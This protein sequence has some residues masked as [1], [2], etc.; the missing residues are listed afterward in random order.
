MKKNLLFFAALLTLISLQVF[1]QPSSPI[2]VEPPK[3]VDVV[4]TPVTLDWNDVIGADCY[5]VEVTTDTTSPEKFEGTCNAP[6]S[7]YEFP[8]TNTEMNTRYYWRVFAC[9]QQGWSQPSAYFNF[10][11]QAPDAIGSIG[12]LSNGV[13]DLIADEKLT[14]SQGNQLIYRLNRAADRLAQS[15]EFYAI[16]EMFMFKARVYIL[17]YSN[18]I[19]QPTARSLNYSADGVIDLISDIESKPVNQPKL[20][21]FLVPKN[22]EVKQNYPNPFNPTTTIEYSI[23]KDAN[24]SLKIFDVLGKEVATLVNDQKSAG[25]YIINW[26]A[27]NFSSG[28]YFYRVTAGDFTDTKKMFLVK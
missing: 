27:S 19:D 26:N 18:M 1:A 6:T 22:F 24:V 9:S 7:H 14:S 12:N 16:L 21:D 11:T 2:L 3:D 25:T 8:S 4:I 20:E 23:P 10:K 13:I 28:L 15:N 17:R 5:R